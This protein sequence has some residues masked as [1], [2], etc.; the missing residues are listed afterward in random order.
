M[1]RSFKGNNMLSIASSTALTGISMTKRVIDMSSTNISN[2]D[3][4]GYRKLKN[5]NYELAPEAGSGG[6]V[7]TFISRASDP[8]VDANL[9]KA[10]YAL[11]EE[12]AL[13]E[14][15]DAA[16]IVATNTNVDGAYSALMNAA[17]DLQFAPTN[18]ALQAVFDAAGQDFAKSVAIT[19]Q[20]F[21]D[22]QANLTQKSALASIEL[23]GLQRKLTDLSASGGDGSYVEANY[24]KDQITTLQ[25]TLSGYSKAMVQAVPI[26][27]TAF[28]DSVDNVTTDINTKN[29][30]T[31]INADGTWNNNAFND[32]NA[33]A[34]SK[35]ITFADA[36]GTAKAIAGSNANTSLL[37][38]RYATADFTSA[39]S[40]SDKAYGVDMTEELV[41]L[42]QYQ[43]LYE[44]N[45]QVFSTSNQ[46][47]G[48]LLNV[49]AR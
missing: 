19:K 34:D 4:K 20:G 23:Q 43:N 21:S 42:K 38:V 3:T 46:M 29:G 16:N 27:E 12:T 35:I 17:K 5:D 7:D 48:T 37:G 8:T 39:S 22:I 25:G 1:P 33:L 47:L 36:I 13:K 10:R 6:G 30:A 28:K 26:T 49:M 32:L 24:I 41:R 45:M 15:T 44:A 18:E 14:G 40:A 9:K 2:A 11:A 31:L